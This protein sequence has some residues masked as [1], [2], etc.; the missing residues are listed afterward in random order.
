MTA[1]DATD[2]PLSKRP[3]GDPGRS[4]GSWLSME[5]MQVGIASIFRKWTGEDF[6][7]GIPGI[8]YQFSS[9]IVQPQ[10]GETSLAP[11]ERWRA[12]SEPSVTRGGRCE[13]FGGEGLCNHFDC[14]HSN[15][16]I[17]DG[18]H[19]S[20]ENGRRYQFTTRYG[21]SLHVPSGRRYVRR[22]MVPIGPT[23]PLDLGPKWL[24]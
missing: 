22:Q 6:R 14:H 4:I 8:T 5:A 1:D 3:V 16:N 19:G 7:S 9:P 12:S 24:S 10:R 20:L 13:G 23:D 15:R 21:R 11:G 17:R 18:V 2:H